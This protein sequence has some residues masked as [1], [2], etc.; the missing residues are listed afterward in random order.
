MKS[1][2]DV[3]NSNMVIDNELDY[4]RD[5][6]DR[7]RRDTKIIKV[8]SLKNLYDQ[9]K[10]TS[11]P[12][13]KRVEIL[14]DALLTGT[15]YEEYLTSRKVRF[16]RVKSKGDALLKRRQQRLQDDE[17]FKMRKIDQK[18]RIESSNLELTLLLDE[19][20]TYIEIVNTS[21]EYIRSAC[22]NIK[23]TI[24]TFREYLADD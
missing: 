5:L 21:L 15:S 11:L 19:I 2:D 3:K 22:F 12:T 17:F 6:F 24:A 10:N 18:T 20:K 16:M 8:I 4:I 1:K 9:S 23:S 7:I 14:V 13:K